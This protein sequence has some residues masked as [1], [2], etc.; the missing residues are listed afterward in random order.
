[1]MTVA[2]RSRIAQEAADQQEAV[3][4]G[5]IVL[6]ANDA[7]GCAADNITQTSTPRL[8]HCGI[9][10]RPPRSD[11]RQHEGDTS[12]KGGCGLTKGETSGDGTRCRTLLEPLSHQSTDGSVIPTKKIHKRFTVSNPD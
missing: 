7:T 11:E 5:A 6:A 2:A 3:Q 9:C 1:M 10:C 12:G 4:F 8:A